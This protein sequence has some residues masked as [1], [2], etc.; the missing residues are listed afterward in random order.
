MS[1]N[2]MNVLFQV[3]INV[4]LDTTQHFWGSFT[5]EGVQTVVAI[6]EP[7]ILERLA[8]P[9]RI[10]LPINVSPRRE[11]SSGS[12]M[13]FSQ[14]GACVLRFCTVH[15]GNLFFQP[16][17]PLAASSCLNKWSHKFLLDVAVDSTSLIE[18]EASHLGLM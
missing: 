13:S 14:I 1:A 2:E 15:L 9:I 4:D 16:H 5:Q 17:Q 6:L 7:Y 10:E 18:P 3:E 12:G 11:I 8:T